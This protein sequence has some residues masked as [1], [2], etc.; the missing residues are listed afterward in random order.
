MQPT[1]PVVAAQLASA[2][3]P[4]VAASVRASAIGRVQG[5][6]SLAAEILLAEIPARI[7]QTPPNPASERINKT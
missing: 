5:L 1:D 6:L 3:G 4:P 2:G 7:G